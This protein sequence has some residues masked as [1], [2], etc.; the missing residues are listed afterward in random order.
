VWAVLGGIVIVS[1]AV[2]I[3]LGRQMPAPWIFVDELIY[4][5]LAKSFAAHGHFLLRGVPAG[6][7]FGFVYPVLIAPAWRIFNSVPEAY[8]A[9]KMIGA[10]AMSL[11]AVP[12]YFLARRVLSQPYALGA[13]ALSVAIPSMLYTGTLMTENAF[14][15][16]FLCVALG[17]VCMLERPTLARQLGVLALCLLAYVTRQQAVVL[18]PAVLAAPLVLGWK[19]IGRFRILYGTVASV[20]LLAVVGEAARGRSPLALLGAYETTGHRHYSVFV[21]AKW[22]L[23]HVGELDLYLAIVPLAAFLVV[24]RRE[25]FFAVAATFSAFL[26]VE[27]AAF[28]TLPTVQR[29]EERNTFYLAPFFLIALLVWIERGAARPWPLA[30]AAAAIAAALPATVPYVR[31]IG[32]PATADTLALLPW[33]KLQEHVIH[34]SQVRLAITLFAIAAAAL[35]LVVPHRLVLVLPVLVFVYFA[36]VQR[37]AESRM[38]MASRGALFQGIRSV[39]RDWI[40]RTVGS[41]SDVAVLWTGRADVHSVWENELFNRSVGTVYYTD[42]PI[43]GGLAST[44]VTIGRDGYL[45]TNGHLLHERYALADGSLDLNGE[46]TKSDSALGINLWR[47]SGPVQSVTHVAGLYPYDTWSGPKVAYTRF[48]CPGGSLKVTVQGDAGLFS[49][50]QTLGYAVSGG[51]AGRFSIVPG[52]LHA[53][54]VPLVSERGRCRVDFTV[55]PTKVPGHGDPRRLGLHFASF[56]YRPPK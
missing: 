25:P 20:L 33:W 27:V 44:P 9:A 39:P 26:L 23:W 5:E 13:A 49:Q 42:Q 18:F 30:V 40:D 54:T 45:R 55:S 37:P 50:P 16:I 52:P 6:N 36:A 8:A 34:L 15:P 17:T 47:L 53:V 3:W 31:F 51:S 14:Y 32:T 35:F 19:G 12:A 48:D 28:T 56:L 22:L 46:L 38:T 1:A 43:P 2:R 21:V 4:S 41:S 11:A 24:F 7:A 29:I 10:V